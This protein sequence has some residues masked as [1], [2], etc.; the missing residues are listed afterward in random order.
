MDIKLFCVAYA[1]KINPREMQRMMRQMGIQSEEIDAKRVIIETQG[2]RLIINNPQITKMKMGGQE[3]LQIV[4]AI[5]EEK[6]EKFSKDDVSL[7]MAQTGC[8]EN[9]AKAALENEG[10]IAKAIISLSK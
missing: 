6:Q 7:V 9:D 8:G 10:D 4:G 1:M 3:S 5:T 2:K